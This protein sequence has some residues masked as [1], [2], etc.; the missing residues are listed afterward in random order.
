MFFCRLLS[1][2]IFIPFANIK[3]EMNE[4]Q[5]ALWQQVFDNLLSKVSA[6]VGD[7][8]VVGE[9]LTSNEGR[10]QFNNCLAIVVEGF[11]EEG[12]GARFAKMWTCALMAALKVIRSRI[13]PTN[14]YPFLLFFFQKRYLS[15]LILYIDKW[16]PF[17]FSILFH[18]IGLSLCIAFNC[19]KG[20]TVFNKID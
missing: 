14:H 12:K 20:I 13:G 5:S 8:I 19:C 3:R 7:L 16:Y 1:R 17:H 18:I 6:V 11:G 10:Q 9:W 2:I 4:E 15:F